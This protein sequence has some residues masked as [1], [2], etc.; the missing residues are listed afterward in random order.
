MRVDFLIV[1]TAFLASA[2]QAWSINGHL[3]VANIAE[4]LL[5]DKAPD[6][7]KAANKMLT[8]LTKHN[9]TFTT[10]EKDH[11]FVETATFA[12]DMKYHGEMWQS[13]FH[14]LNTAWIEEGK[15]SDYT[16]KSSIRN[17]TVGMHDIT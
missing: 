14:F 4:N 12:D 11:A 8:Y 3:M 7:L 2:S 15:E 17:I 9:S 1:I 16:I 10:H 5:E 6:S 13:D